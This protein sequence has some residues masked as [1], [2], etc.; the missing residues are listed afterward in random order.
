MSLE[1]AYVASLVFALFSVAVIN[2]GIRHSW[3]FCLATLVVAFAPI[4]NLAVIIYA[5]IIL[6]RNYR[7]HP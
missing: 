2:D 1:L 3:V 6:R 7:T 5:V 4:I